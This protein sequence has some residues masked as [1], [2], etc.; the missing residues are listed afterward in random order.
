MHIHVYTTHTHTH[1][2]TDELDTDHSSSVNLAEFRQFLAKTIKNAEEKGLHLDA[3]GILNMAFRESLTRVRHERNLICRAF[4]RASKKVADG[5]ASSGGKSTWIFKMYDHIH[6]CPVLV[7]FVEGQ[8]RGRLAF[9]KQLLREM[10]ELGNVI[11]ALPDPNGGSIN[12]KAQKLAAEKMKKLMD[13]FFG[14][15]VSLNVVY[16]GV[17]AYVQVHVKYMCNMYG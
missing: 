11:C 17:T 5:P 7:T 10:I 6:E 2:H 4:L 15:N 14:G 13:S 3:H 16:V 12:A 8:Q 9:I 1:T